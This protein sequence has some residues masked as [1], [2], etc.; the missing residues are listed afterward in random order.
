M[1]IQTQQIGQIFRAAS[2]V[3]GSLDIEARTVE[4]IVSTGATRRTWSWEDG[5]IDE[6]LDLRGAD[7]ALLNSGTAPVLD[8]HGMVA[9]GIAKRVI[10]V[11]AAGSARIENGQLIARLRFARSSAAQEVWDLVAD[12][13]ARQ[14]SVGYEV[15][16]YE[17]VSARERQDIRDAQVPL[18]IARAWKPREVSPVPIGAD[19]G[20]V[21]RSEDGV[22]PSQIFTREDDAMTTK[23]VPPPVPPPVPGTPQIDQAALD[24]AVE[25]ARQEGI[26]AG[27]KRHR[28]IA[29]LVLVARLDAKLVDELAD[30]DKSMDVIRAEVIAKAAARDKATTTNGAHVDIEV[31]VEEVEKRSIAITNSLLARANPD[32]YAYDPAKG[33]VVRGND[34]RFTPYD[35]LD[36]AN[37]FRNLSLIELGRLELE[38]RGHRGVYRMTPRQVADLMFK[39]SG[40]ATTPGDLPSIFLNAMNKRLIDTAMAGQRIYPAYARRE[41]YRDFRPRYGIQMSDLAP[42]PKIAPDDEYGQIKFEDTKESSKLETFGFYYELSRQAVINDDLRAFSKAPDKAANSFV[43]RED[44]I[45]A[46][47]LEANLADGN[48]LCH[49]SRG[50]VLTTFGKPGAT[51]AKAA[52]QLKL[53]TLAGNEFAFRY[54]TVVV[55]TDYQWEAEQYYQQLWTPATADNGRPALAS[56]KAVVSPDAL[57]TGAHYL[58][59]RDSG[60]TYGNLEGEEGVYTDEE[61]NWKTD[62]LMVKFRTDFAGGI[63]EY[64]GIV[65]VYETDP[66]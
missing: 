35:K 22:A 20:A 28:E 33:T 30:S 58:V 62:G 4:V 15:Q 66:S 16:S 43:L 41:N 19:P 21:T 42:A 31:G 44:A 55:P 8:S 61:S 40:G 65:K 10:G 45:M 29:D 3:P 32:G 18:Y 50:N 64:L 38:R 56:G 25:A 36:G 23:N 57:P 37:E 39:R 24:A 51:T 12:G 9:G 27:A 47:L 7:L 13:I 14:V 54:T 49:S 48:P 52:S 46:A 5:E 63:D 59:A 60:L 1:T 6:G 11:V 34:K 26:R 2:T 17:R 53:Q